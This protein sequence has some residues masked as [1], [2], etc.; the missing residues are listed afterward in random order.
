MKPRCAE[1]VVGLGQPRPA[2]QP[3]QRASARRATRAPSS[4]PRSSETSA[5]KRPRSGSSPP[6]TLVPPPNGTTATPSS[7]HAYRTACDL[8]A[9]ARRHDGVGRVLAVAGALAQQVEVGLAAAA[10]RRAPR[11]RRARAPPPRSRRAA[12]APPRAAPAA[13]SRT[14]VQRH[15][16]RDHRA[17]RRRAR[18]AGSPRRGRAATAPRRARPSPRTRSRGGSR[19]AST[20]PASPAERLVG[21]ALGRAPQH[22]AAEARPARAASGASRAP[23]VVPAAA[24]AS[25]DLEDD[26]AEQP[27]E[28]RPHELLRP[29]PPLARPSTA[30]RGSRPGSSAPCRSPAPTSSRPSSRPRRA[31]SRGHQRGRW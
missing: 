10:P 2:A 16:P 25:V 18:S 20:S 31:A 12:R 5:S 15:R 4:R 19:A 26:L 9:L 14:V 28:R 27:L 7:L 24:G 11:R 21:L 3:R 23:T 8:A 1:R 6:T 29:A 30:R 22:H 17:R 13:R